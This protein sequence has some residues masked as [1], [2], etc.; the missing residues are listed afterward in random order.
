MHPHP[1]TLQF[2]LWKGHREAHKQLGIMALEIYFQSI[3]LQL[4]LKYLSN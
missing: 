4:Q 3:V 1:L 2:Q